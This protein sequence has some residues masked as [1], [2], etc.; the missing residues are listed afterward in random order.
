MFVIKLLLMMTKLPL[1]NLA[2]SETRTRGSDPWTLHEALPSNPHQ[3]SQRS[4]NPCQGG[5]ALLNHPSLLVFKIIIISNMRVV[6][7][8]S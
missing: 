7:H 4:W 2:L 1:T 6:L 5:T 3:G 8:T